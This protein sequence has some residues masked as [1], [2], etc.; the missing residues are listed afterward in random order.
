MRN[1]HPALVIV[2]GFFTCGIYV[3]YWLVSTKLEMNQRGAD[4]PTAWLLIVPFVN[5]Y[6]LWRWSQG[7][8]KITNN[9]LGAVPA[10]LLC[11]FLG[12]IG[13]AITQ[14]YFNKVSAA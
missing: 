5:I 4:I 14:S 2:L 12:F 1:R 8:E 11:W 3:I 6:W 10:F 7:V 9:G 13:A